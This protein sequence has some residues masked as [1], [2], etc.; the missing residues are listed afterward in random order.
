MKKKKKKSLAITVTENCNLE[1]VYCYETAKSKRSINFELAKS[2]IEKEFLA[3]DG[4]EEMEIDF[5]GGEPFLEFDLIKDICEYIWSKDW[6]KKYLCYTTTN[7][8]LVHGEVKEWLQKN[9][10]YFWC[11]LS[12]D[13]NKLMHDLNRSNS[14][15]KIDLKFFLDN[16]PEQSVKMT[17]SP[18]SLPYLY[19]GVKFIEDFGG[20]LSNNLAYGIDWNSQDNKDILSREL[21]KLAERY[22]EN[23]D[24]IVCPMINFPIERVSMPNPDY[25]WCGTG[26]SMV[27]Y[28]VEGKSYPCHFFDP[29]TIGEEKSKQSE[30]LSFDYPEKLI[31]PMCEDCVLQN[32]CPTCYGSNFLA[33]GNPALRD[34]N[35]CELSKICAQATAYLW[36]KK[37]K[38]YGHKELNLSKSHYDLLINAI[39]KIR[40]EFSGSNA[41]IK[42]TL[43][44][45]I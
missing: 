9:K 8:T 4:Y 20:K 27:A 36:V 28:S 5:H 7:G 44:Q 3:D 1:C 25:K 41:G 19:D 21:M 22:A 33:T 11:G 15:D 17:L 31:D 38:K 6:P 16:W 32:A 26:V 43:N 42:E 39:K 37:L 29:V 18:L 12:L 10:E 23:I 13:G 24:L 30:T 14:F 2:I 40:D 45:K 35:M 34:K